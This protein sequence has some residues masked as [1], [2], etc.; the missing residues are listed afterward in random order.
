[1]FREVSSKMDLPNLE[2]EI[3]EFW[4]GH[5]IFKKSVQ[6]HEGR[7]PKRGDHSRQ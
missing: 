6:L 4:S 1:M 5:N 7:G 2:K 3:L